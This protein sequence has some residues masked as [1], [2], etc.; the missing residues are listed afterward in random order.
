MDIN[1]LVERMCTLTDDEREEF[2]RIMSLRNE[3]ESI[4]VEVTEESDNQ[5][6]IVQRASRNAIIHPT[7]TL[8]LAF[9]TLAVLFGLKN[10]I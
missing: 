1:A 3:S 7:R 2:L 9:R 6:D 4:S 8:P 5:E 10:G